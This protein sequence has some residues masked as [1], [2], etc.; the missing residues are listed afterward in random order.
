MAGANKLMINNK[1][2]WGITLIELMIAV[3]IV[4]IL[5]AIAVPSYQAH[6][7]KSNRAAASAC[8]AEYAQFME[9]SYTSNMRYNPDGFALPD[10]QCRNDINARYTVA[11]KDLAA[12]SYQLTATPTTLQ[13]DSECTT[14]TLDQAGRKGAKGG[15]DATVVAKCW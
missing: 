7:V 13:K 6:I 5:A 9:R 14:L 2:Q 8:L 11:I 4:G 15:F 3:A 1:S 12:R 10:L